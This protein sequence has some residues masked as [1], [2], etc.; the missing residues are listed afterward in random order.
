MSRWQ[1]RKGQSAIVNVGLPSEGFQTLSSS[2]RALFAFWSNSGSARIHT[3]RNLEG[4][5]PVGGLVEMRGSSLAFSSDG[6]RIAV[7]G[8]GFANVYSVAEFVG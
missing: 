2:R 5:S 7:G 6:A 4:D 1:G 8:T 3:E